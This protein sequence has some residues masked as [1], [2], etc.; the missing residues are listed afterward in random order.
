MLRRLKNPWVTVA[1]VLGLTQVW[2]NR[3]AM[4]LDG[5]SYLDMGDAYLRS[6]WHTAINGYWNPLYAW[7]TSVGLLLIHPSAYWEYPA[8]QCINFGIYAVT[9]AAF[10]YFLRGLLRNYEDG[11][12]FR[13][14]AYPL[15]LWSSIELIQV[16]LVDPDM[17]LAATVYLAFGVLLRTPSKLTPISLAAAL[18][19]GYYAKAV[20]FP[21]AVIIL[22][23]GWFVLPR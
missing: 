22:V 9:V 4:S 21:I 3:F 8:V 10:E 6:D 7:V 5:T 12:P 16:S 15:F 14:I 19:A 2:A 1:L 18:A 20:L 13:F 17:L 11:V 23:V